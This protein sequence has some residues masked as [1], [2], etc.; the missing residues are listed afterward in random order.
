MFDIIRLRYKENRDWF[1]KEQDKS[2]D[3]ET[4]PLTYE[5]FE[6]GWYDWH[7]KE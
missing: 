7:E 1:E 6:D 5:E 3:Y 4:E 2:C